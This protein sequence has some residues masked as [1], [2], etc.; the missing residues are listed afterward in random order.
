MQ[1]GLRPTRRDL[2]LVI[3]S[4]TV[5]YVL[6]SSPERR[7]GSV[8]GAS[9]TSRFKS[10]STAF[11]GSNSDNCPAGGLHDRSFEDQNRKVGFKVGPGDEAGHNEG[12]ELDEY[13]KMETKLVDHTPG[14]TMFEKLYLFNGQFWVLT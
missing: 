1:R 12:D 5:A 6:F 14:W 10:L 7:V 11:G 4:F 2:L 3:L 8:A 9:R 13:A